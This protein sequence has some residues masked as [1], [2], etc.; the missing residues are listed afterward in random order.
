MRRGLRTNH[1]FFFGH[2]SVFYLTNDLIL[3][4][5][6]IIFMVSKYCVL[7]QSVTENK[8]ENDGFDVS[9]AGK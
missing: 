4:L 3:P 6:D 5:V 1:I 9:F 2:S 7:V 8:L